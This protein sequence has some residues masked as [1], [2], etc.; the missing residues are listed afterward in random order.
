MASAAGILAQ[1]PFREK[2]CGRIYINGRSIRS[3]LVRE[4]KMA[5][6]A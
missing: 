4:R 5:V 3:C 2:N 6:P 1:M